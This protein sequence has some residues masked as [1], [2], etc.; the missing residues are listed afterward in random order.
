MADLEPCSEL[1]VPAV[2]T[3]SADA[4]VEDLQEIGQYELKRLLGSGGMS[5]VFLGRHRHNGA[6]VAVKILRPEMLV[7]R[8]AVQ[9]FQ[10]EFRAARKLLHPNLVRGLDFGFDQGLAY[11][12]LEYIPGRSLFELIRENL[13]LP[14]EEVVRF[15][16]QT[17]QGL[18][19]AHRMNVIHRDIKPGNI[20]VTL[21]GEAKLSDLGLAK[22]L[23]AR[24][25]IT[26]SG[27]SLGTLH[28][29]APEQFMNARKADARADIYSL[30]VTL[31]HALTG[32]LPFTGGQLTMLKKKLANQFVPPRDFVPSLSNG[33]NRLIVQCLQPKADDRPTTCGEFLELLETS[34]GK[35][36]E[37]LP[38]FQ[39]PPVAVSSLHENRRA[40][41]RIPTELKSSC[42]M[43]MNPR[44]E[45]WRG[46]VVDISPGG[47]HLLVQR[48]FEI[49]SLLA[50][51]VD[52]EQ[53]AE[54][55]GFML[56]V[57]WVRQ[58]EAPGTWHVGGR[59]PRRMPPSEMQRL[60]Q[61]EL[62]T[63]MLRESD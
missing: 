44:K 20:L 7:K 57:T 47:A 56:S 26:R 22:D 31:Y 42:S 45:T 40:E 36:A 25:S 59:F 46:K 9:R 30:G 11:L 6:E 19:L 3:H 34:R 8:H 41:D 49:G 39:L 24:E 52:D 60:F 62:L 4:G 51:D 12:V 54:P 1:L 55:L 21:A 33:I 27:A 13:R 37:T 5:R 58:D 43:P 32:R 17:A 18:Q 38:S 2:P 48:R 23:L 15:I 53:L 14:E 63:V 35:V 50:V 61:R 28:Y 16:R 10:S 29:M